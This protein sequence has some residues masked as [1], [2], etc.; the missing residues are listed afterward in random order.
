MKSKEERTV[1][2]RPATNCVCN[3]CGQDIDFD[4]DKYDVI[5]TKQGKY[6]TFHRQCYL[7]TDSII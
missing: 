2:M 6:I 1:K 7:D 4:N 5:R 3:L